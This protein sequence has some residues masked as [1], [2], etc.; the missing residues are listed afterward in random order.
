VLLVIAMILITASQK[1]NSLQVIIG[2]FL[3][4]AGTPETVIKW[5][6]CTGLSVSVTSILKSIRSLSRQ[7]AA[8]IRALG[9]KLTSSLAYNNLE[10]TLKVGTPTAD[11]RQ[12]TLL[13][14]TSGMFIPLRF[15]PGVTKA[16][17]ACSTE[18]WQKS[19]H[20]DPV[21]KPRHTPAIN[22]QELNEVLQSEYPH[23]PQ[24]NG[25]DR[26]QQFAVYQYLYN[27]V[28]HGPP[29]FQD[30]YLGKLKLV[31][32]KPLLQLPVKRTEH[33]P[34]E[35]V[36]ADQG[37]KGRNINAQERLWGQGDV[38]EGTI[39]ENVGL[40]HGDLKTGE[41]NE[42]IQRTR[43]RETSLWHRFAFSV[44][45]MGLFHLKMVCADAIWKIC[46]QASN[47]RQHD[48]EN[49]LFTFIEKLRPKESSGFAGTKSPAF[50]KMHEVIKHAGAVMRCQAD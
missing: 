9:S 16:A 25:L 23:I 33:V 7:S 24:D 43:S 8:R 44:F 36:D 22:Y 13:K 28:H 39:G 27:L 5:V 19:A 50:Q 38:N 20:S 35:V 3:H 49:S 4:A 1:V 32:P 12:Q 2:L 15:P 30:T 11:G 31:V 46:V 26:R 45:C 34:L 10:V 14:L 47:L 29:W 48:N 6:S 42:N 18:L 41:M 37:T 17:L 40:T 21:P